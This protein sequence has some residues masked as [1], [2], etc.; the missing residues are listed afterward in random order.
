MAITDILLAAAAA[1]PAAGA[2]S[3]YGLQ[4]ALREGGAI[5]IATFAVDELY[6]EQLRRRT[7][8]EGAPAQVG[9]A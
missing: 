9:N 3:P 5:A 8:G 4:A 6:A 7:Q 2:E 1:A